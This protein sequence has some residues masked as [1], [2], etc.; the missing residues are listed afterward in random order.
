[1]ITKEQITA[2]YR[3]IQGRAKYVPRWRTWTAAKKFGRRAPGVDGGGGG[4]TRVI[5]NGYRFE[6]RRV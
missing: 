5:Q 6:K 3:A 2:D 1:M 4:R